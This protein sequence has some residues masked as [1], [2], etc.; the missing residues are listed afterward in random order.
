MMQWERLEI[1]PEVAAWGEVVG[2]VMCWL[3][4]FDMS[5]LLLLGNGGISSFEDGVGADGTGTLEVVEVP[6]PFDSAALPAETTASCFRF[7]KANFLGGLK[8]FRVFCSF[9]LNALIAW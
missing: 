7:L 5:I 3:V 9:S 2:R 4:W 6:A 8:E 1:V